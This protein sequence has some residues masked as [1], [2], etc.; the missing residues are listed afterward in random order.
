MSLRSRTEYTWVDSNVV[1]N[2]HCAYYSPPPPIWF[3]FSKKAKLLPFLIIWI[4]LQNKTLINTHRQLT[5]CPSQYC[6]VFWV[7]DLGKTQSAGFSHVRAP[8]PFVNEEITVCLKGDANDTLNHSCLHTWLHKLHHA[9]LKLGYSCSLWPTPWQLCATPTYCTVHAEKPRLQSLLQEHR[10]H[11]MRAV[12]LIAIARN[13][14]RHTTALTLHV[15]LF[16]SACPLP[17][18][19]HPLCLAIRVDLQTLFIT[20]HCSLWGRHKKGKP[21]VDSYVV[22]TSSVFLFCEDLFLQHDASIIMRFKSKEG[23]GR[24]RDAK[25]A[26]IFARNIYEASGDFFSRWLILW[27]IT[28]FWRT[29]SKSVACFVRTQVFIMRWSSKPKCT[30]V[31]VFTKY[32]H[33]WFLYQSVEVDVAF[34]YTRDAICHVYDA[35]GIGSISI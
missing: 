34:T 6:S 29:H 3:F 26:C 20:Q 19:F 33:G 18:S 12:M 5:Q 31:W 21:H 28:A 24:P 11:V 8:T 9:T 27:A 22:D 1:Q 16:V 17:L 35:W 25:H 13:G 4:Y 15:G 14:S 23:M 7:P 32:V 10:L 30:M 2:P